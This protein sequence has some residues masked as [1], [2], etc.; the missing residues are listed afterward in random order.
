MFGAWE[1]YRS[2]Q[3]FRSGPVGV[4]EGGLCNIEA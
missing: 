3:G 1:L 2:L 4:L